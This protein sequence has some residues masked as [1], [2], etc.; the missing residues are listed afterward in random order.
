MSIARWTFV[1]A[2]FLPDWLKRLPAGPARQANKKCNSSNHMDDL[3]VSPLISIAY[4]QHGSR[5]DCTA[6]SLSDIQREGLRVEAF[7]NGHICS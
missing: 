7:K 4:L 2:G 6:A 3:I 1:P 5:R